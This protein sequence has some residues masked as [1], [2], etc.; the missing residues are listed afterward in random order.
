MNF[1][2]PKT[3]DQIKIQSICS[4]TFGIDEFVKEIQKDKIAEKILKYAGAGG[5]VT[6]IF[7][8]PKELREWLENKKETTLFHIQGW[9]KTKGQKLWTS[10]GMIEINEKQTALIMCCFDHIDPSSKI[11]ILWHWFIDPI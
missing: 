11:Q 2:R 7:S 4:T 9:N 3:N 6:M 10:G 8:N 5:F 1:Y